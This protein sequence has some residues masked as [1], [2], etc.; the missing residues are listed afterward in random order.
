VGGSA[1]SEGSEIC[2][3]KQPVTWRPRPSAVRSAIVEPSRE[4]AETMDQRHAG[5]RHSRE[6]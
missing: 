4:V 3:P 6:V 1:T 2:M 5:D